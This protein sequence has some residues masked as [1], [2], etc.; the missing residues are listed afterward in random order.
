MT[1]GIPM[2]PDWWDH[3]ACRGHDPNMWFPKHADT[4]HVAAKAKAICAACPVAA[5]CLQAGIDQQEFYGIWGG[6][7]IRRHRQTMRAA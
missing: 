5:Q 3:A 4:P 6:V 1:F 2:R 7:G